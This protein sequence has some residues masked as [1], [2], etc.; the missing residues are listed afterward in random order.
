MCEQSLYYT[1]YTL[2]QMTLETVCSLH[3]YLS[4]EHGL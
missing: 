1:S 4:E 2:I 3:Q